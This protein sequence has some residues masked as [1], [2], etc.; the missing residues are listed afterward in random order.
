MQTDIEDYKLAVV[1]AG[2]WGT[3]LANLLATKGYAIDHWVFEAEVCAQMATERENR[4]FLP[5]VRLSANL[6]P[7]SDLEKVVADKDLI[8]LVVPSHVMRPVTTRLAD[9]VGSETLVVCASKGIENDT[10]LTM[11]GVLGETLPQMPREHYAVLS[12]PSFAREV[13]REAPTAVTVASA[14]PDTAETV[15]KIFATPA[16]RVY[17][18][19]DV[20]GVEL[21]G[22][23]KNVIAIAAGVIDGLGMG[24]NT[25]AALITRGLTEMRRLGLRMGANPRTFPGLAG[26]GDLVLTCTG[27]LSRNHTVGKKIG[28]GK[29]LK[30]LLAEMQMVAEGVKTAKSVYNL[31]RKLE[32]EM[33]ISHAIYRILYEDLPPREAA[34]QLMTR[35]LKQELDET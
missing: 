14:S 33:P 5:G 30:D 23:V 15:Q 31:S 34:Y 1:G 19:D 20:I 17:A 26:M 13:A 7:S 27:D 12:G 10:L 29:L 4:P 25:R 32:V 3:A 22:S 35:D 21:G 8:L 18:H 9:L 24:L 6:L 2:S 28:E 11:S 16:F